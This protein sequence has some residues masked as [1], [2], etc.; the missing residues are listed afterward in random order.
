MNRQEALAKAR[1]AKLAKKAKAK[2]DKDVATIQ[3][4]PPVPQADL[5][6][7]DMP[8]DEVIAFCER[9][10]KGKTAAQVTDTNHLEALVRYGQ[11]MSNRR[12]EAEDQGR[13][14]KIK[15]VKREVDLL[16]RRCALASL[17]LDL[18]GENQKKIAAGQPVEIGFELVFR[19]AGEEMVVSL[20]TVNA[21][22]GAGQ[23]VNMFAKT[24]QEIAKNVMSGCLRRYQ[25]ANSGNGESFGVAFDFQTYKTELRAK[26]APK[27][28]TAE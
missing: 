3:N 9:H 19:V 24:V 14:A 16:E 6:S 8:D 11:V 20:D 5:Y 2:T 21:D 7:P 23:Q 12:G 18:A 4:T 13:A 1:A 26:A 28:W 25:I 10:L 15:M 27:K 22:H 17:L